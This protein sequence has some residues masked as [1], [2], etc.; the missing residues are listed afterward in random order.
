MKFTPQA[1]SD[2]AAW[3]DRLYQHAFTRRPTRGEQQI[4]TEMLG[5]PVTAEGITDLLW[6]MVNLPEFQLIN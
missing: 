6:A 4:A 1:A 3:L 5:I 2:P